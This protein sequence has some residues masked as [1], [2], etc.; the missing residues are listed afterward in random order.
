MSTSPAGERL[1]KKK[2]KTIQEEWLQK[3][4]QINRMVKTWG[5]AGNS[6]V[7]LIIF[8]SDAALLVPIPGLCV[9]G[10]ES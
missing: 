1:H 2:E 6:L 9:A 8:C 5:I 4:S 3:T 7:L 10:K